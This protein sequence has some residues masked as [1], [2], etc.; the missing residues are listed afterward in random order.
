MGKYLIYVIIVLLPLTAIG[1]EYIIGLNG[2]P[3]IRSYVK[4]LPDEPLALK[5]T[6]KIYEPLELPFNDDFSS[7]YIYPDT[8][9][10][11]DNEA[12]INHVY[13]VYPPNFGVATLDVIDANGNVYPEASPFPFFAD[14]MTSYPLRLDN[15]TPADSLYL[16]FY[17]QPQGRGVPP[18]DYDSLVVD[19]GL[20]NGDTVFSYVDSV[21]VYASDYMGPGDTIFPN[22]IFES[23][24][25]PNIIFLLEDTLFYSDSLV[26]PCDSVYLLDTDW[27]KVWGAPGDSLEVFLEDK[28]SFFKHVMIPITDTIWFEK[29]FQFRFMNIGSV[30]NISSWKSNTDQWHVDEVYLNAGRGIDDTFKPE[31]RFSE[32]PD[33]FI[34]HYSSM[35]FWQYSSGT[36]NWDGDSTRVFVNNLDSI[37]HSA[38]YKYYVQDEQGD[39]VQ[40]FLDLYDGFSGV[41]APLKDQDVFAHEPFTK[42]KIVQWFKSTVAPDSISFRVS[43]V[44]YDESEVTTGDTIVFYEHFRNYFAYDDGTAEVGYGL[45]PGGAKLAYKFSLDNPDTIRGMQMFFNKTL[46]NANRRL[47]DLC[48]WDN[49]NG[50]PGNLIYSEENQYPEFTN[51]LNGFHNYLF[52]DTSVLRVAAG[53]FFIGWIQSSNHILNIGFDRNTNSREKIF[54]NVDG[55]WVG[56]SFD[57]SLMMRMLV[58]KN[59]LPPEP[60]G[61]KAAPAKLMV[62]PNPPQADGLIKVELPNGIDPKYYDYLTVRIYDIYGRLVFS[63]PYFESKS[64]NVSA[65]TDGV[66]I[67]NVLDEAYSKTYSTKLL[68]FNK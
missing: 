62:Y 34:K 40:S 18:L 39:T 61:G 50:V 67:V 6:I 46:G 7:D 14:H 22:S 10:W 42:P 52:P 33:N 19:F 32:M 23:P 5:S 58:G 9:R 68:I 48:V 57:G 25:N 54:F 26:L 49:N 13:G 24:C 56:S 17:Y 64:I 41:V 16:S 1:Q 30:S 45:T 21:L 44:V 27:T 15:F 37:P 59:L 8:N 47:F 12:F 51:G 53:D 66:Y 3:V 63:A 2:N 35:P 36:H 11:V 38:Y 65:L 29:D 31:I 43:H 60:P 55:S 28:G 20:Y 4:D